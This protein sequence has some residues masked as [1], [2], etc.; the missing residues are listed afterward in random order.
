MSRNLIAIIVVVLIILGGVVL[1]QRSVNP[2]Q[3]ITSP[4]IVIKKMTV[5]GNEFKF[6]PNKITMNKGETLE[7]TFKNAGKFPHNFTIQD[8]GIASNTISP[9]QSTTVTIASDR[10]GTFTFV[11]TVD[12]HAD[13]GMKGTF[14]IK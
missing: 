10:T 12:S 13:R 14:M 3:N 2:S 9:G 11:C 1:L 6:E 7:V 8:L 4:T 5:E